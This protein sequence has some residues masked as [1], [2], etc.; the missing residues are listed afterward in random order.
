MRLEKSR[1]RVG[2]LAAGMSFV[3]CA[4]VA[5]LVPSG[6]ITTTRAAAADT[7][8]PGLVFVETPRMVSGDLIERFPQGSR[9]VRLE[10]AQNPP[11]PQI[12]TPEFF[13]AADPSPSFDGSKLLFAAQKLAGQ[14]WQV[15]EMNADGSGQKQITQCDDDCLRADYLPKNEIVYSEASSLRGRIRWRLTVAHGDGSDAHPITFGPGNFELETVLRNG[16]V[17]A[18][19]SWPLD[20]QDPAHTRQ[21]YTLRPDGTDLESL[22]YEP[23]PAGTEGEAAEL[24]DGSVVFEQ[25]SSAEAGGKLTEI[26]RGA[27]HAV[28]L[29]PQTRSS[30]WPSEFSAGQLILSRWISEAGKH[31]GRFDLYSFDL[32]TKSFG[33]RIYGDPHFSSV[34]AVPLRA[35]RTPKWFWSLVDRKANAGRLICLD[36]YLSGDGRIAST[37]AHVRV[38][39]LEPGNGR[40]TSLG[41][42]P[43]ESD[44]SFYVAVPPD[45]PVRFELLD[46]E[47]HLIGAQ[48]GWTWARPG[49]DRGCAG[50][51]ED[52]AIAP[53]N[54]WPLTLRRLDTPTNM[55]TAKASGKNP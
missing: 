45:Q 24:E 16:L 44:G 42:A 31:S 32:Q 53:Q 23:A 26:A 49:E 12:L 36:S 20:A 33:E 40:E 21:L 35:H 22:R 11:R 54:R 19:A 1:P 30:A 51:H 4:L 25:A 46:P 52:R 17:V 29:G 10:F 41:Q 47:G 13:A 43:V 5:S 3:F 7:A 48:K 50:C 8:R 38:L 39:T 55:T 6:W 34:Q 9:L 14:P 15:W 37:I 28:P 27:V 2:S 18:S